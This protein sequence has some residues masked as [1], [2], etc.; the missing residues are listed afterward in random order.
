MTIQKQ[1]SDRT[2]RQMS[3][4][5]EG[6]SLSGAREMFFIQESWRR[7]LVELTSSLNQGRGYLVM[8]GAGLK[9]WL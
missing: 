9:G 7:I 8:V 5:P 6:L 1:G 4:A 2:S 3:E